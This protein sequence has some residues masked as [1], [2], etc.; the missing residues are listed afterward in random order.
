MILTKKRGIKV[1]E[2]IIREHFPMQTQTH[3]PHLLWAQIKANVCFLCMT[4]KVKTKYL[5]AIIML[6]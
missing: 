5:K 1:A 6:T 4:L 2:H 3:V